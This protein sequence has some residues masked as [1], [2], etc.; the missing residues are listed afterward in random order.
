M[1]AISQP[2][3]QTPRAQRAQQRQQAWHSANQRYLM[4]SLERVRAALQRHAAQRRADP[5]GNEAPAA[6]PLPAPPN[7]TGDQPAALQR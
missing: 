3:R 7:T 1:G 2:T 5:H 4:A 6:A